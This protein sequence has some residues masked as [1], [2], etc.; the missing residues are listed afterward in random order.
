MATFQ[1][2]DNGVL[3]NVISVRRPR[4]LS[5]LEA[6]TVRLLRREGHKV[7]DIAAMLGTNQGRV[8]DVLCPGKRSGGK[9]PT[10]I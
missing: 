4:K 8:A 9:Q 1:H 7:Q 2:P 10:L 6:E 5:E 3:L